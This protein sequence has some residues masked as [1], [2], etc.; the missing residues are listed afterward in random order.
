MP[1]RRPP[2]AMLQPRGS[3]ARKRI[4]FYRKVRQIKLLAGRSW[5]NLRL[6]CEDSL[7]RD[8]AYSTR[9]V[10]EQS[11]AFARRVCRE[12][13]LRPDEILAWLDREGLGNAS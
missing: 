4:A 6:A 10:G 9:S 11:R 8:V 3:A 1:T 2:V 7:G 12:T 5:W 13:G